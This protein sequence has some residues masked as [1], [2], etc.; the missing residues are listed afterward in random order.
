[1]KYEVKGG[2]FPV[3]ICTLHE[4]ESMITQGGA[5]SWMSPNMK[6][7]TVGGGIKSMLGR[8]FSNEKLFQNKY[9][10][11][12]GFGTIAF[13]S[14]FP[15]EIIPIEINDNS[16]YIFQ[17]GAFLA[18][19]GP[20]DI[21]VHFNKKL[22]TSLFGG[23]GFIMEKATGNGMIF[24]EVDGGT[25]KNTLL[26]GQQIIVDTGHLV[27]MSGSCQMEIVPVKGV[28]NA[29]FGGEGLFNTVITGPGEVLLQTMPIQRLANAIAPHL[30]QSPSTND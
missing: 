30:P 3:L 10:S 18:S 6:M 2:N 27:M 29:L 8:A 14:S 17:K 24:L 20:V 25:I 19:T 9:T 5:M 23:E 21:S 4:G 15:G 26:E 22:S 11:I 13:A 12:N 28:K 16:E 1:M 7:E